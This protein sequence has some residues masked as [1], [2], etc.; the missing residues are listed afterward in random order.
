MP[1]SAEVVAINP[2]KQLTSFMA[3]LI[4]SNDLVNQVKL[5]LMEDEELSKLVESTLE[6]IVESDS[7]LRFRGRL[8][9]EMRP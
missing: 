8:C 2:M 9:R 7:V 1:M 4:I 3:N 6:I 5:A